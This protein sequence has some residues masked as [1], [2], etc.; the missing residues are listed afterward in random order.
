MMSPFKKTFTAWLNTSY[1]LKSLNP[2]PFQ[3]SQKAIKNILRERKYLLGICLQTK[4]TSR[5]QAG[6]GGE[7]VALSGLCEI[8]GCG[9]NVRGNRKRDYQ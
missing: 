2:T 5:R 8:K 9:C 7:N 1:L 4:K 6:T 3:F